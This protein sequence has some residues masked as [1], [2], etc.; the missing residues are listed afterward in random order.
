MRHTG[1]AVRTMTSGESEGIVSFNI[2]FSD[3][4]GNPGSVITLTG[5][6]VTF[7]KTAPVT[8]SVITP[9]NGG[10]YTAG[11]MPS[12]SPA[13]SVTIPAVSVSTPPAAYS[14]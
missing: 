1:Q 7:D 5:S 2:T 13:P 9:A 10:S 8:A 11:S 6:N 3:L 14:L 12:C 4:A